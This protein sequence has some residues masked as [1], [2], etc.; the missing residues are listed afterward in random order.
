MKFTTV[1]SALLHSTLLSR[2]RLFSI[3]MLNS[4]Y[5]D[6]HFL[7]FFLQRPKRQLF[8]HLQYL[9]SANVQTFNCS[10]APLLTGIFVHFLPAT[11]Y[12]FSNVS[13]AYE[14]II[15]AN[16]YA[17]V[18]CFPKIPG[19][20]CKRQHFLRQQYV[21]YSYQNRYF[22]SNINLLNQYFQRIF[23]VCMNLSVRD[24]ISPFV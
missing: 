11:V 16:T 21:L 7:H 3:P 1:N 10:I 6:F 18:C 2:S 5:F 9:I 8:Y 15:S 13:I 24:Y 14:T 4:A 12:Y 22:I 19:I 17:I 20:T 23:L